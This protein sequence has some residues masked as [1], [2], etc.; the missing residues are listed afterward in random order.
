MVP[1]EVELRREIVRLEASLEELAE[2]PERT[3]VAQRLAELEAVYALKM[4]KYRGR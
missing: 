4:G 1:E 3:R 2:G